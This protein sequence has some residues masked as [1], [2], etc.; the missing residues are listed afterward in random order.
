MRD[1]TKFYIDGQWVDP[2]VPKQLDVINPA[3]E[4]VAGVISMGSAADADRAVMAARKAFSGYSQT[5]R[6]DRVE[7]LQNILAKYQER[8]AEIAAA[9]TEEMG[10][11]GWL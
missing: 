1:Y 10:A 8:F 3:T 9:I 6:A 5:S 4:A 7:L 2:A 11:P